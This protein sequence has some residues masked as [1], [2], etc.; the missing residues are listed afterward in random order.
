MVPFWGRCTTHFSL[1]LWGLG[2]S[3]GV[4]DWTHGQMEAGSLSSAMFQEEGLDHGFV[5]RGDTLVEAVA[6]VQQHGPLCQCAFCLCR[7][8]ILQQ[9]NNLLLRWMYLIALPVTMS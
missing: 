5:V 8:P 4:R 7:K 9:P 6:A 1:S 2:C 3:L